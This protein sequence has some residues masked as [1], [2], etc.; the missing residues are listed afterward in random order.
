VYFINEDGDAI[1]IE[2]ADVIYFEK[3]NE[4]ILKHVNEV[5]GK[6]DGGEYAR[7]KSLIE[8]SFVVNARLGEKDWYLKEFKTEAEA[9]RFIK[10]LASYQSCVTLENLMETKEEI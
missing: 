10:L 5:D 3:F 9:R 4:K 2:K 1:N 8:A 6:H 7:D